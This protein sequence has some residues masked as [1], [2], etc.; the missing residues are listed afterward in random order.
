MAKFRVLLPKTKFP[1]RTSPATS[2][3]AV[4]AAANFDQLYKWQQEERKEAP[5]FTLHD[6]PPYANGPPH[7]G[8]ALNKI[9]KD[10]INRYKLLRGFR[11]EYQPGWDCHGLPIELKACKDEDFAGSSALEIRSKASRFAE[12]A[13]TRQ[14]E[15]FRSWGCFGD[16]ENPYLT[17]HPGYEAEQIG[18]FHEMYKKGCIYRGFKPVYW[19]PSSETALA[20][21]ELEYK[22]HVSP[23]VYAMFP[24]S[25]GSLDH[26]HPGGGIF[27][28]VWTTTP[29]TLVANKAICYHP[30]HSYSLV[31]VRHDGTS[32]LLL[33]GSK[34]LDQLS[35]ILGDRRLV[36]TVPGSQLCGVRYRSPIE[37]RGEEWRPFLPAFHVSD[38]EGTGLVHTAPSHG[39]DDYAIGRKNGL[40]LNCT[41]DGRGRYTRE[42]GADLEGLDVLDE[43]NKHILGKLRS[44]GTLFHEQPYSHRYPYDWRTKKPV[45]IR[46]THQWFADVSS[47][48]E[49]ARRA[50]MG[51]VTFHP[52]HSRNRLL[53]FLEGRDD[54]C[55]SRQRLWGVPLPIF[56]RTSDDTPLVTD[57]TILHIKNLFGRFGSDCWWKLSKEELLPKSL[58]AEAELYRRG[59]DTMDVW[60]DSGSSW[61]SVLKGRG[62][63]EEGG[64]ADLYL[65]G[66]DQHRGWF[67]SSLL[68]SVAV[69]GRSPYRTLLTHGFVLDKTGD[70]MSKSLGNA[71]SPADI[72]TTLDFG[73]DVMRLWVAS[74]DY[75]RDVQLSDSILKQN[76]DFLQRI[77]NICRFLLGNLSSFDPSEDVVP[78]PHLSKLDKYILHRL[79][80]FNGKSLS[81]YD[82]FEFSGVHHN[83]STFLPNDLSS[84]YFDIIKDRLYCDLEGSTK[85][86]STLTVLY[87]ILGTVV[88]SVA[89]IAPHL[90]EEVAQH[91]PF[92]GESLMQ[93][94]LYSGTSLPQIHLPKGVFIVIERVK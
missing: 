37:D 91:P 60:F 87:H 11:V 75:H 88:Q 42:A 54:W 77:R 25:P 36:R 28:L 31:E 40:D 81:S 56:Y 85:R 43:G 4:R 53:N 84:F 2:D 44:F 57:E 7:M 93:T 32:K 35:S 62:H 22:E 23:S 59:E 86:R 9:L 27:A 69:R 58:S 24:L 72:L 8:H 47:L 74:S 20:E 89:P 94:E 64:V 61:A 19:S 80:E 67:Q 39:Y 14:R 46:S 51:G 1:L 21:A 15:E 52:A 5:V 29:W 38:E 55:I 63:D 6:G 78:Y 30:E 50:V 41:V 82:A 33:V 71:T 13:L 12:Q 18:V 34:C 45:I 10:I 83:L 79:S 73:A 49:Q 76:S 17:M 90:A 70:K 66:S 65:E 16:W 48:K 26:H 68:T 92:Q 3:P